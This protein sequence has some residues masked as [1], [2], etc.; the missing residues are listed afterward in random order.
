M[1]A[2]E[3]ATNLIKRWEGC[4][5]VPYRD[6]GGIWTQGYGLT[7][8]GQTTVTGYSAPIT[9]DQADE[10]L[11]AEVARVAAKV[12]QLVTVP[13]NDNQRASLYDFAFNLGWGALRSSTLLKLV[14]ASKFK[15][16]SQEFIKWSYI[17]NSYSKGL[18]NRR[19]A[20]AQLFTSTPLVS[21]V[22]SSPSS[23]DLN[24]QEL[25]RIQG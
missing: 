5:L 25:E 24:A 10:L 7:H 17:R 18:A 9:Q 22:S 20:E 3:I 15:E 12:D 2:I 14:N 4:S 11:E 8:I 6:E 21:M 13:L 1:S 16:A 19:A 23:D